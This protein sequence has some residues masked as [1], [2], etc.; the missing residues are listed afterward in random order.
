MAHHRPGSGFD[1]RRMR[2]ANEEADKRRIEE[3]EEAEETKRLENAQLYKHIAEDCLPT[4]LKKVPVEEAPVVVVV[5]VC[6]KAGFV[7]TPIK[8]EVGRPLLTHKAY[9]K[10]CEFD[11][12]FACQAF[13]AA[14]EEGGR[15]KRRLRVPTNVDSFGS[16]PWSSSAAAA[17]RAA[18]M[19]KKKKKPRSGSVDRVVLPSG[20]VIF[21]SDVPMSGV[22]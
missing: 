16:N 8:G 6:R 1:M 11:Y 22:M 7:F 10:K 12:V 13:A 15:R 5:P 18:K 20:F 17:A 19:K 14:D 4:K 9:I 21:A 2:A 3:E